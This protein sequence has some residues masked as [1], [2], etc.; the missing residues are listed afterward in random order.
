MTDLSE[1]IPEDE[2]LKIFSTYII[3]T[4]SQF[5]IPKSNNPDERKNEGSKVTEDVGG[6]MKV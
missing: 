5:P 2:R 4:V 6:L 3:K 1:L